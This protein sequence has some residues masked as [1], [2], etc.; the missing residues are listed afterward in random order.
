M[1]I[2]GGT[3]SM[4]PEEGKS[5]SRSISS[6]LHPANPIPGARYSELQIKPV[7]EDVRSGQPY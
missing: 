3:P 7:G 5:I 2:R 6:L 4:G 1:V